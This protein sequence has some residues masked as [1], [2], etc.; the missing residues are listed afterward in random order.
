[1]SVLLFIFTDK[2]TG[3]LV[4]IFAGYS[5]GEDPWGTGELHAETWGE[6]HRH[7]WGWGG[8]FGERTQGNK[9]VQV[10][11]GFVLSHASIYQIVFHFWMICSYLFPP[12]DLR[13]K[14]LQVIESN[15]VLF[16]PSNET[17]RF[18]TW[19]WRYYST[20]NCSAEGTSCCH[21]K[22]TWKGQA[23]LCN[24]PPILT[25]AKHLCTSQVLL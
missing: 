18:V 20:Y 15:Q 5:T 10:C 13:S 4:F 22:K 1:M 12:N 2:V 25:T 3:V 23:Y 9:V 11:P 14:A 17:Q 6:H 21:K 16:I 19:I 8:P 24:L 7:P